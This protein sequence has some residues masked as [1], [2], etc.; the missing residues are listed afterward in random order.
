M[1]FSLYG[2]NGEWARVPFSFVVKNGLGNS[3]FPSGFKLGMR[4]QLGTA[5][6]SVVVLLYWARTRY[7]DCVCVCMLHQQGQHYISPKSLTNLCVSFTS[8]RSNKLIKFRTIF[9]WKLATRPNA[10][11]PMSHSTVSSLKAKCWHNYVI[12]PEATDSL[13]YAFRNPS[14]SLGT[15]CYFLSTIPTILP[16]TLVCLGKGAGNFYSEGE[17]IGFCSDANEKKES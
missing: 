13:W 7:K 3:K 11:L 1:P 8:F 15:G 10:L 16:K 5:H 12:Q 2:K 6:F 17:S 14:Q 9:T 4:G